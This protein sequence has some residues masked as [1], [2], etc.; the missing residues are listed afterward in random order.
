MTGQAAISRKALT[1]Q[2]TMLKIII[3]QAGMLKL[4][5]RQNRMARAKARAR[6]I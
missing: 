5:I 4:I 2:A 6:N 1:D 3:H